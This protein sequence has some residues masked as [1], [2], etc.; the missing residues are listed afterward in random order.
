MVTSALPLIK[1]SIVTL[2]ALASVAV[3]VSMAQAQATVDGTVRDAASARPLIGALITVR[4][5]TLVRRTRTDEEGYFAFRNVP[6][7]RYAL[8]A[9]HLGYRPEQFTIGVADT[10]NAPLVISLSRITLLDT[11]RV[12]AVRQGIYGTVGRLLDLTPLSNAVV[13]LLGES[14]RRVSVDSTGRFFIPVHAPGPYVVRA[15]APAH[16]GANVSLTVP[17]DSSVEVVL[18]LDAAAAT[19]NRLEHAYADFRERMLRRRGNAALITRS[20]LLMYG[21]TDLLSA[22]MHSPSFVRRALRFGS[23]ACVFVDGRPRP[24]VSVRGLFP[25]EVEAVEVYARGGDPS[26]TLS[27]AWTSAT[28][29]ATTGMPATARAGRDVVW[30]VSVWLKQ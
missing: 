4:S 30:W 1:R 13:Q 18:L 6:L 15:T 14:L 3:A 23:R 25:D 29:C 22:I 7:G 5:E 26:L 19:A 17:R 24:G 21:Y 27:R 10:T 8:N 9:Q 28:P 2:A 16:A 20:E 12:R 11:V